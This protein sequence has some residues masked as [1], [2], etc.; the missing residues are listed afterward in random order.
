[1]TVVPKVTTPHYTGVIVH[2]TCTCTKIIIVIVE[3]SSLIVSSNKHLKV[4]IHQLANTPVNK[5]KLFSEYFNLEIKFAV[6]TVHGCTSPVVSTE[7]L[8]K[9]TSFFT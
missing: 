4:C 9:S 3:K 6:V 5:H 7:H 2:I 8:M 1:M